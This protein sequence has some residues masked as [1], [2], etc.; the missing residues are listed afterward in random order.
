MQFKKSKTVL[1]AILA[2][3][4]TCSAVLPTVA[5][6]AG[7]RTKDEA[8]GDETYA[9]RF[10]SLYDDVVTNGQENGYLSQNS[11]A[12]G[13]FGVPYHSVE[14]LCIEAPDY[15][16]ETTSEALSYLV[17][18]A[19]MRDH[20]VQDAADGKVEVKGVKDASTESTGDLAKAWLTMEASMIPDTQGSSSYQFMQ[21]PG[22]SA[23]YSDEWEQ[24]EMYPTDMNSGVTA[25]NPIHSNFCS[26]YGSDKGLYLMH[27]LADVDDWYGYGAKNGSNGKQTNMSGSFTLINTFQRGEQE[28]CW[29]TIPHACVD[30]HNK[31]YGIRG[32]GGMKGFFNTEDNPAEQ[33]SYTNAPDAEDRA[34]QAVYA[35]NRW[36][37][38]DVQVNSKWGGNQALSTLAGKM[39]DETRNNMYDKYYKEIGTSVNNKGVWNGGGSDN[40]K[41]YLMNWYTS[42]GGA[43]DQNNWAWQIGASH[44]HEFYQS[45]IAAYG[46]VYD[47]NLNAGM[48]ANGAT[49]DFQTSL[50]RQIEFYLWLSSA[51]GPFAG[52]A[53][54]SINGRYE[55]VDKDHYGHT[56]TF[57][58]ML[59]VEH[60]VYADPGSNHWI[61]NQV[62]A[63][64]RLAELYYVVKQENGEDPMIGQTGMTLSQAL[65]TVLDKWV[66]WFL[67]Y[68]I[69][70][71]ANGTTTF[72][73]KY[74][75]YD[76][77]ESEFTIPDISSGVV[78]DGKSYDV[79]SSLI[80]SGEP[81]TWTGKYQENSNLQCTIVGY[82]A[83]M[84]CV[85]SLANT[86]LYY[87][88]AK[89][90]TG[91]DLDK[92][93]ASYK[94]K[95]TSSAASSEELG[96][97]S[98]Y[99]AKELLDREWAAN[100]DDIGLA[101]SDHNTNLVRL[102]E[103]KLVLPD[104]TMQ[105]GQG[106]VLSADRYSG[107]M[108][109][110]DTIK[111]G[112]AFV[113][114][115][116]NYKDCDMYQEALSYYEK[117]GDT[118]D[119][120]FKIHRFW[121][122]GDIMMALGAMYE[123]YP[124]LTP[125][126]NTVTPSDLTVDKDSIELEVGA[127]DVIKP[128]KDGCT[129]ESADPSVATVDES[130]TVT[131]VA[132]GST[133]VTVKDADGNTVT[134]SVTVTAT[135]D[136]SDTTT[137]DDTKDSTTTESTGDIPTDVL[138]G[139][140]NLD[141]RIDLTDAILLNKYC[142][143]VVDLNEQ[144]LLNANCNGKGEVDMNDSISLLRFL[145]HLTTSL[146]NE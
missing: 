83:D 140:V 43:Y 44:M 74:E 110:G 102:W 37:I 100:R 146:P 80:W 1:S 104:G 77:A 138:L 48:K 66:G 17:W 106:K 125:D 47:D 97:Q 64:Q 92:A 120:Y 2:A 9:Q 19:A 16:H 56:S 12:N 90:V 59:Y 14:E 65:E 39:G 91:Q 58:D 68:S 7:D 103:T 41:H 141:G 144:Q 112:V 93:E 131:G 95:T 133:T 116:S 73:A 142:A 62:W 35:A 82:N 136:T 76:T 33:W 38:G 94:A 55:S 3:A 81:N 70:G 23:T 128:S 57:Y 127:T 29:E 96:L 75:P 30:M 109:N 52:G 115:R 143:Q 40:G 124:E 129:F 18:V 50:E 84:G 51:N 22:L 32:N 6:A 28:S 27:W 134:V 78:D 98:L 119:Y 122:E 26:A 11:V 117:D 79:P 24:I 132:A 54:N 126:G 36:G 87:S 139:D 88:K 113:D 53:T 15:G 135:T 31:G 123:L 25:A 69:L 21:T 105:N 34:I 42:W 5:S 67:D 108:P 60:P 89:G 71:K 20:I 63:A 145:V 61:G 46:L 10:M 99:L 8:Y 4:M 111:N 101:V 85:S 137:T 114:I 49:Q 130:G 13:G 45:P 121:H 107:T 72:K 118:D 86:L